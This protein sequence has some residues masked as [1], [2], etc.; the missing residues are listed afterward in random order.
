MKQAKQKIIHSVKTNPTTL[1]T[2]EDL[3][4]QNPDRLSL[5]A[6][7]KAVTEKTSENYVSIPF[8]GKCH[9]I[10]CELDKEQ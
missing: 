5:A 6:R 4:E 8:A 9:Q 7:A 3:L 2:S 10:R 1:F